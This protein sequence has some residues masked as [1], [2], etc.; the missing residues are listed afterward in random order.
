MCCII[1]MKR[2]IAMNII[3]NS[4]LFIGNFWW[5][6]MVMPWYDWSSEYVPSMW[7]HYIYIYGTMRGHIFAPL[8]HLYKEMLS[9]PCVVYLFLQF[10]KVFYRIVLW[11]LFGS[12]LSK[13][14]S[15]L[16]NKKKHIWFH[17]FFNY[18]NTKNT[19]KT[20]FFRKEE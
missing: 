18:R 17:V 13:L 20:F 7:T 15:E 19:K 16:K 9:K 10:F 4:H 1:F 2:W 11:G 14:F 8:L 3:M 12:H 6:G 5:G